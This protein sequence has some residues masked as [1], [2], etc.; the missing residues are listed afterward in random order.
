MGLGLWLGLGPGL[1]LG[2]GLG[3]R[4]GFACNTEAGGLQKR[5]HV[6]RILRRFRVRHLIK[7]PIEKWCHCHIAMAL[8]DTKNLYTSELKRSVPL[9]H[10]LYEASNFVV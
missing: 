3:L 5:C 1:G 6:T 9:P 7:E 8:Y 2:L 10:G 4:L